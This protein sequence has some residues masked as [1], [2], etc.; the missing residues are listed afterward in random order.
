[1]KVLLLDDVKGQG[2]KGQIVNVSDGYARNFLFPKKLAVVADEKVMAEVKAK[3]AARE[4]KAAEELKAAKALIA[5]LSGV[6]VKIKASAGADGRLY[7]AITSKDVAEHLEKDHGIVLDK[8]KL[9]V[10]AIK[11]YGLYTVEYRH[12][13]ELV[14]KFSLAVHQ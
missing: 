10:D 6:T 4:Y 14:A 8:R 11:A 13:A 1:M 2:K 5:K 3:E 12:S 7:G 9:S